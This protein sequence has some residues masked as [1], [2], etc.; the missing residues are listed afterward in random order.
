MRH[1]RMNG[2]SAKIHLALDGL[3]EAWREGPARLIVAPSSDY[4]ERAYDDAKYGRVSAA[5]AL[6]IVIPTLHDSSLAPAGKHVISIMAQFAPYKLRETS[7]DQARQQI[8][9]RAIAVMAAQAPDL[10]ARIKALEVLTPHDLESQFRLTGGQWHHGEITLDQVF[11]LR[12]AGG[13]QQYRSPIPGLWFC[14][15][16][17]HP[18]GHVTGLPGANAAREAL[19]HRAAWSRP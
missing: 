10:P 12:P 11:L 9:D 4:V 2:C 14:G 13:Y 17:A 15:A 1:L 18:G 3:P 5:P 16:G 6:E 7:A 19:R 8:T